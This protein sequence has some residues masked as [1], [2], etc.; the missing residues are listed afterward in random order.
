MQKDATDPSMHFESMLWRNELE[1]NR[2]EL[3]IFE[4]YL[5]N[6][7]GENTPLQTNGSDGPVAPVC[8]VGEQIA[9]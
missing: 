9:G 5:L 4:S 6:K 8:T 3:A 1:Y 7:G 2:R